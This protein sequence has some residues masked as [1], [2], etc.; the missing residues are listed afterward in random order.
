MIKRV[1]QIPQSNHDMII[2]DL[3]EVRNMIMSGRKTKKRDQILRLL[4]RIINE[5]TNTEESKDE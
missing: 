2:F 1:V 4:D 5:L 3:E